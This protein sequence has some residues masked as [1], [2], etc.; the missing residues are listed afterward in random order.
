MSKY[1]H[2]LSPLKVQN[3]ILKNRFLAPKG[4]PAGL[5]EGYDFPTDPYITHM[6]NIA[7]NGAAIVSCHGGHWS[8]MPKMTMENSVWF[9]MIRNKTGVDFSHTPMDLDMS[10]FHIEKLA[11]MNAWSHMAEA[12]HYYDSLASISMMDIEP[13]GYNLVEISEMD[14]KIAGDVYRYRPGPGMTT[15][16]LDDLIENFAEKA[17]LYKNLGF[18]MASFYMS[19]RGSILAQSLSPAINNRTDKYGGSFEA[20]AKLTLDLFRRVKEVCGEDFLIEAQIT[21]EEAADGYSVEDF[22]RYAKM[23]E[24]LVDIFQIRAWDGKSSHPTGLN[25]EKGE[26]PVTLRYAQAIKEAGIKIVTAPIGGYQDLDAADRYIAEGRTDMIAACRAFICDSDYYGKMKAG[27][28]DEVVPCIRCNK[29]HSNDDPLQAVCSVNPTVGIAD[30]LTRLVEPAERKKKVVVI[31]GGPAGLRASILCA[32]RGHDVTLYEKNGRLGGQLIHADYASFKWPLKDFKDYLVRV[33]TRRG[34]K[35]HVG[36]EATLE[37]VRAGGYD[38]VIAANGASPKKPRIKGVENT[39]TWAPIDVYGHEEEL[40]RRVVVVGGAE[41]GTETALHLALKGKSVT[42]LC[43]QERVAYDAQQIHYVS[44]LYDRMEQCDDLHTVCKA[45]TT[46]V[47]DGFVRYLDAEGNEQVIECED[48]VLSGGVQANTDNALLFADLAEEYYVIGDCRKPSN[49][50][51][52]NRTAFA[53]A[54]RI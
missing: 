52:A 7:K 1:S 9:E 53:V 49:V 22:V 4:V 18:D 2:L 19:Y 10:S 25:S 27:L 47:G 12:I 13:D 8:R 15:Q 45:K 42:L 44:V 23:A 33:A 6:A 20:R 17:L 5:A 21:G 29:C 31:G 28:G 14:P 50:H 39:R 46:E 37:I 26:D 41:T 35:L 48:I 24:G 34:V 40:G 38:V 16:Q 54:S 32:E 30:K 36:E 43:R 11:N 3:R 51:N